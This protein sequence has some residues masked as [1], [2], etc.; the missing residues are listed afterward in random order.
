MFAKYPVIY[1]SVYNKD[2]PITIF[3]ADSDFFCESDLP[4]PIFTNSVLVNIQA[5][6]SYTNKNL[7]K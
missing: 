1:Q 3:L 6:T 4:I 2:A 7:C 5:Y